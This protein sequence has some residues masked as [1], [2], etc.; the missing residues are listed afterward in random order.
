MVRCDD[1]RQHV[2]DVGYQRRVVG[3]VDVADDVSDTRRRRHH[4]RRRRCGA[5]RRRHGVSRL[6]QGG[7]RVPQTHQGVPRA[8]HCARDISRQGAFLQFV[9]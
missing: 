9:I 1:A 2:D 6:T 7:V 3:V 5:D 8:H 4:R